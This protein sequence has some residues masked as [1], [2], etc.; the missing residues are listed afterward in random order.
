MKLNH[1]L[2]VVVLLCLLPATLRA[3][4][5]VEYHVD[6]WN[7]KSS[8]VGKKLK[9]RNSYSYDADS[10]KIATTGD[11]RV[12][13]REIAGND[14]YYVSKGAEENEVLYR[15]LYLWC[16]LKKFEII[17]DEEG[18][19]GEHQEMSDPIISGSANEKLFLRLCREKK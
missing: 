3:E 15:R 12:W 10:V 9:F 17:T 6:K 11:V 19:G 4:A 14:S 16:G 8:R 2:P 18:E 1:V 13:V 7:Y 5:W